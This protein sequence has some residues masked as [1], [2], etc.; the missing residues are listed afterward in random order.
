M[1]YSNIIP[2]IMFISGSFTED[3]Y[4]APGGII[5]IFHEHVFKLISLHLLLSGRVTHDVELKRKL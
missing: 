3:I 4:Y 5:I 2:G 1:K